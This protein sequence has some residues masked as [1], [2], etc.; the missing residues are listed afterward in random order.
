M[1]PS[2][3]QDTL[4]QLLRAE[5]ECCGA[6]ARL[7]EQERQAA[8]G[9]DLA[10]LL[11]SNKEREALQAQWRRLAVQRADWLRRR[12]TTLEECTAGDAAL[13]T[14]RAELSRTAVDL[15]RAQRVNRG[16]IDAVLSQV[17]GLLTSFRR[18]LPSS[19]YG[20]DAE[21]TSHV[22]QSGSVTLSA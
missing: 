13:E 16:L 17:S 15:Q 11:T 6:L 5:Q 9:Q 8:C 7:L 12:G 1:T 2:P 18:E 4:L 19:R 14:A 10:A 20:R 22:P 21:L 3:D